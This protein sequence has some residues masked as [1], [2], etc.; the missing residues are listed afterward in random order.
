MGMFLTPTGLAI[1]N[2]PVPPCLTAHENTAQNA[3]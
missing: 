3:T 2:Q 1:I